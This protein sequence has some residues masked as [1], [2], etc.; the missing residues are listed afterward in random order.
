MHRLGEL[1]VRRQYKMEK[2]IT[3]L[4]LSTQKAILDDPR[5]KEHGIEALDNNGVITLKGSVPS[6]EVSQ[7]AEKVVEKVFGVTSVINMLEIRDVEEGV[8]N[9][10]SR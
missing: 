9:W 3:D 4:Q 10:R 6:Q 7:T 2:T 1:M 5:T 8:L